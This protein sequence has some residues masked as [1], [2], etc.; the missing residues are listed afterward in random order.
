MNAEITPKPGSQGYVIFMV[1]FSYMTFLGFALLPVPPL[2]QA[3]PYW[4]LV[5]VAIW[6]MKRKTDPFIDWHG[7]EFIRMGVF[8]TILAI[9]GGFV[10]GFMWSAGMSTA[11]NIRVLSQVFGFGIMALVTIFAGVHIGTAA[12]G[13]LFVNP[14]T[15]SPRRKKTFTG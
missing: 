6:L 12:R 2:H 11:S 8:A 4:L 9:I 5:A 3:V 1:S 10:V 15:F 14:L 13:Q 7:R